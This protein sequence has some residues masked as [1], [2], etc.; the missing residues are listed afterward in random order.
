MKL[1]KSRKAYQVLKNIF[2]FGNRK[3][4]VFFRGNSFSADRMKAKFVVYLIQI[5]IE[6]KKIILFG[7]R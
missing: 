6:C 7:K 2:E 3:C 1:G 4:A 5:K